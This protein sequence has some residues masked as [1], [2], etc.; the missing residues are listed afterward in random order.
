MAGSPGFA[1]IK[2]S[3]RAVRLQP[4]D[5]KTCPCGDLHFAPSVIRT[6]LRRKCGLEISSI[7]SRP[8]KPSKAMGPV[9]IPGAFRTGQPHFEAGGTLRK[10]TRLPTSVGFNSGQHSAF[11]KLGNWLT[12]DE[13]RRFWQS[14]APNP[15]RGMRDRAPQSYVLQGWR[16]TAGFS[17]GEVLTWTPELIRFTDPADTSPRKAQSYRTES[18]HSSS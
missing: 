14:P 10:L 12:V 8:C 9:A 1:C 5:Q 13:A 17:I 11:L 7:I 15:L 2:S 18:P 16:S 4:T 3:N 6:R